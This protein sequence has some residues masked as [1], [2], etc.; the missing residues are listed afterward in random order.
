MDQHQW[1]NGGIAGVVF[2]V[3]NFAVAVAVGAP[4]AVDAPVEEVRRYFVDH[5]GILMAILTVLVATAPLFLWFAGTLA[6]RIRAP[7]DADAN[8]ASATVL[9][10]ATAWL[11]LY[12]LAN[13]LGVAVVYLAPL[14]RDASDDLIRYVWLLSLLLSLAANVFVAAMMLAVGLTAAH[15]GVRPW[16][17][18]TSI[19]AGVITLALSVVAMVD[20]GAADAG[21]LAFLVVSIWILVTGIALSRPTSP[22]PVATGDRRLEATPA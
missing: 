16:L 8:I 11:G 6:V 3:S 4:P 7:R 17:G 5:R 19:G 2:I 22:V 12:A 18:R 14:G 10:G 15:S 21:G 9:G 20:T 1:R 13:V